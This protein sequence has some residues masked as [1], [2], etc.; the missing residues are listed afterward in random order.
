MKKPPP[1]DAF[2]VFPPGMPLTDQYAG[3]LRPN[4]D[5]EL[6][7]S[8]RRGELRARTASGAFLTTG[9]RA[10]AQSREIAGAGWKN[11]PAGS[12]ESRRGILERHP[13]SAAAKLAGEFFAM[14]A[15]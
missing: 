2:P 15:G 14:V 1:I 12:A 9:D 8:A 6:T 3:Q 4:S 11:A 10:G 7:R 13:T 5:K